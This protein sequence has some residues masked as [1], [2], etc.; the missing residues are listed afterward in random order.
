MVRNKVNLTCS[1]TPDDSSLVGSKP[2]GKQP[3]ARSFGLRIASSKSSVSLVNRKASCHSVSV[4]DCY[5][6]NQ[7]SLFLA[8]WPSVIFANT[9][10]RPDPSYQRPR[11]NGWLKRCGLWGA[12]SPSHATKVPNVVRLQPALRFQSAALFAL[13]EAAEDVHLF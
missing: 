5:A 13:Q 9:R 2:L 11:F 3:E 6:R 10:K 7:S 12:Y 4:Y 8:Q 1:F